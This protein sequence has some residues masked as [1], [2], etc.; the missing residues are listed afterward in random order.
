MSSSHLPDIEDAKALMKILKKNS[1]QAMLAGGCVRDRIL[2]I[3]P[4][5]FDIASTATPEECQKIFISAGYRVFGTGIE[6]GT[7]TVLT[8]TGPVEITTLR[9]DVQTNGRHAIVSFEGASFADDAARRDFTINALYEDLDGQIQDFHGGLQDLKRKVIRF[10]GDPSDRIKEDYLR[11]LRF[12]RFWSRLGF[13]PDPLALAAIK[14]LAPGLKKISQ[15]RITSELWQIFQ[16]PHCAEPLEQM[17]TTGVTDLI[18]PM[19]VTLSHQTILAFRH[20]SSLDAAIRPW[21]VLSILLG[22]LG[23]TPLSDVTARNTG[24]A[25]RLSEKQCDVLAKIFSGWMR[26][27]TFRQSRSSALLFAE[28]LEAHDASHDLISFY[29][30]IWLFLAQHG[31][32]IERQE[33]FGWLIAIDQAFSDLRKTPLPLSGIDVLRL[34]PDLTGRQI[35]AALQEARRAYLDGKWHIHAEG[36]E[37]L[38][39]FKGLTS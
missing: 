37:F 34:R 27:S 29:A 35:G 8:K 2:G 39:G 18:L 24:R 32:D 33:D 23:K 11:I 3:T 17:S 1:H 9:K 15:E 21:V 6:H 38:K 7:V 19:A 25:L 14:S 13:S 20:A 12:F 16:G 28:E 5:D 22:I 10:V 30:P 4:K 31:P 26:T 36:E